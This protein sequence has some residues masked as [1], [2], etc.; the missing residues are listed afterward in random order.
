[1]KNTYDSFEQQ[2][3]LPALSHLSDR[4]IQTY[5]GQFN[6]LVLTTK[7]EVLLCFPDRVTNVHFLL[8]ISETTSRAEQT[9]SNVETHRGGSVLTASVD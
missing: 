1:M 4:L 8:L 3:V 9:Q 2:R 5:N 7:G 6:R